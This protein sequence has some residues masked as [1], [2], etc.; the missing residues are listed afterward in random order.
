MQID[1]GEGV[2][3]PSHMENRLAYAQRIIGF[4]DAHIPNAKAANL[5]VMN[6][7][8]WNRVA[9]LAGE[10]AHP[11]EGTISVVI[12]MVRG[13]ELAVDALQGAL[14]GDK[15]LLSKV[16]TAAPATPEKALV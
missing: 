5:C 3:H 6:R 14:N 4:L 1:L 12:A 15:R 13:R 11:A 2:P 10:S 9:D 16:E 7:A 8:S